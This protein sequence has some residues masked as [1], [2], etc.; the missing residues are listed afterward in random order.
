MLPRLLRSFCAFAV[1]VVVFAGGGCAH[2]IVIEPDVKNARVFV[3]G[4]LVGEGTQTIER[5]VIV[6]DQL[7]VSA[8]A[9]G[10]DDFAVTVDANEWYPYPGA[11]ALVPLLGLPIGGAVLIAGLP[12]LGIGI[13][14]GPLV[15]VG[16]AVVTSPTIASLAFTRKYPDTIK[17]KMVRKKPPVGFDGLLPSDIFGV[18]DDLSPNPLPDVGPLPQGDATKKKPQPGSGNPVP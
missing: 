16:W 1:V 2:A 3:D 18:P 11:L 17:I 13:I 5:R 12:L 4:E 15:G 9:D 7:R 6:G 14:L 8:S 10:Y